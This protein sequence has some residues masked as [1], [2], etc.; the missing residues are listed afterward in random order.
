MM[1]HVDF[2]Q[3][4]DLKELKTVCLRAKLYQ[5]HVFHV[6]EIFA[7]GMF[8]V[9]ILTVG[10]FAVGFFIVWTFRRTEFSPLGVFA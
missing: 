7:V 5:G 9:G 1:S 6:A 3:A 8:T 10:I 4:M 2:P